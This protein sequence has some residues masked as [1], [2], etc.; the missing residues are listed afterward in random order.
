M[1]VGRGGSGGRVLLVAPTAYRL[2]GV[3][4]WLDTI[5]PDL[6]RAGWTCTV[7]LPDGEHHDAAP[8]LAAHPFDR[9]LPMHNPTGSEIGRHEAVARAFRRRCRRNGGRAAAC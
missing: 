1:T 7:A 9:W 6:E 4:T 3:Q 2:G 8:Y 5:V